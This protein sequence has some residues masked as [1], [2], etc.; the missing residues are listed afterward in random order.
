MKSWTKETASVELENILNEIPILFKSKAFSAEHTRWLTRTLV[1]LEEVFGRDSRY[2]INFASLQWRETS[3][4][5]FGGPADPQATWNPQAAIEKRHHQAYLKHLEFTKGLLQAAL[6]QIKETD[7]IKSVYEGKNTPPE[8]SAILKIMDIGER[9]L[10]KAVR[11]KPNKEK[12][13]QDAF[14]NLLLGSDI[15]YSRETDSIEYSA[16]T[17]TPDFTFEKI[18]LAV[19]IK[20]CGKE[21]RVKEMIAEINDDI[22]AYQTKYSNLFFIVYDLG[23]I[24]DVDRFV[25][26]FEANKN[27]VV[28]IVKH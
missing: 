1:F 15:P 20:F 25:E 22:L 4:F 14:E 18:S 23:F 9:K 24:R 2:Y 21:N 7:D 5:I 19:E 11:E 28:R 17:Y 12:D 6:D 27:V 13:I 10:R 16:K 8:S 26:A 3:S